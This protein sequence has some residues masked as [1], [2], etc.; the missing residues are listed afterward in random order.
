MIRERNVI[1]MKVP[2]PSV[3][4]GLAVSAHMYICKEISEQSCSFIKCQ[5]LKPQMLISGKFKHYCDEQPDISR[6]PFRRATRIDCD[7]LFFTQNVEYDDGLK[8]S[9]RDDVCEELF[10]K[11]T[12]ELKADGYE[13]INIDEDTLVSLNP[14]IKKVM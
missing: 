9:G 10:N 12:A 4:G 6:N 14:L 3:Q 2:Y 7:K 1:R 5:S 11:V 8:T 13:S